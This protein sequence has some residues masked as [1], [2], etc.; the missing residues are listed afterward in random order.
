VVGGRVD[1]FGLLVGS[2]GGN[3]VLLLVIP[4]KSCGAFS[5]SIIMRRPSSCYMCKLSCIASLQ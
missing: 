2:A 1:T 3:F 5:F 4:P